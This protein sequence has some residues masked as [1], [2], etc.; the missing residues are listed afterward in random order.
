[1]GLRLVDRCGAACPARDPNGF[2][3]ARNSRIAVSH[4]LIYFSEEHSIWFVRPQMYLTK[5]TS[6]GNFKFTN[7]AL[8][9]TSFSETAQDTGTSSALTEQKPERRPLTDG[10]MRFNPSDFLFLIHIAPEI[11]G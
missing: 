1:M 11:S 6:S 7:A 10:H 5:L 8:L 4:G 9:F 2:P 3:R